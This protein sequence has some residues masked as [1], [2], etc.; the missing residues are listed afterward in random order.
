MTKS[1]TSQDLKQN[2]QYEYEKKAAADSVVFAK[3]K[4]IKEIEISKQKAE[5]KAKR[6]QQYALYG[7]LI[8]VLLFAGF[9]FNRF[10]VSQQQKQ[11]IEKQKL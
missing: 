5:L 10:K 11:V 3:E 2:I 9:I 7:G 4:E 6:N 1:R 8:L